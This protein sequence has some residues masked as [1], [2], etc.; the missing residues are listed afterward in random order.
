VLYG[1]PV[2]AVGSKSVKMRMRGVAGGAAVDFVGEV[3]IVDEHPPLAMTAMGMSQINELILRQLSFPTGDSEGNIY[4]LPPC[5]SDPVFG[6][7]A[8]CRPLG[9]MNR[10]AGTYESY[11][12]T[13]RE[14]SCHLLS[15][16][17]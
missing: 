7:H 13:W 16:V 3:G 2:V 12:W 4:K 14:R 5:R 1:A 9:V 15:F 8:R 10:S 17:D 11:L 6:A